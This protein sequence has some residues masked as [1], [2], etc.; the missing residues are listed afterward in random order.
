[1]E[2]PAERRHIHDNGGCACGSMREEEKEG[3]FLGMKN[4]VKEE[5]EFGGCGCGWR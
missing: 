2:R 1:M 4:V 3:L 5:E